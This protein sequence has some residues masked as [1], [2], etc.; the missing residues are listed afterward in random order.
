[1]F[2]RKRPDIM[3]LKPIAAANPRLRFYLIIY[4]TPWGPPPPEL[5]L[6][7]NISA[8]I[9]IVWQI[10]PLNPQAVRSALAELG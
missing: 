4:Y 1:M 2:I 6:T 10:T 5:A 9:E 8:G 3:D 7:V